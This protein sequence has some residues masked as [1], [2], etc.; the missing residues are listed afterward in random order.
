MRIETIGDAKL[1]LGDCHDLFY[2]PPDLIPKNIDAVVTDPPYGI[3]FA[4]QPTMYQ[5]AHG[6]EPS[7]WDDVRPSTRT[8]LG[9]GHTQIIWGG[10]Y[11]E[12]PVSRGWLCWYKP[13]APPSM[14]SFELAWTNIDMNTRMFTRSMKASSLEKDLQRA[15]HPTQ[16][17]VSLMEWCLGFV[18]GDTTLD[19]YMG[20][21]TT[22]VACVN[23]G[24]RFIGIEV[25]EPYFQIACER[26]DAA[27]RQRR[28]FA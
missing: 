11:F 25:H 28:L 15:P 16:K 17:P 20:S 4:S 9:F 19:P 2:R 18:K 10:N 27:Y 12:L 23:L 14:G 7:S 1:Y 24:R 5:R 26:I 6:L 21:G 8:L 3:G 13:D 22:G